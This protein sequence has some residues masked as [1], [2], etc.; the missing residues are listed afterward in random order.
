MNVGPLS[1]DAN[2]LVAFA[3]GHLT[4]TQ[5]RL[6]GNKSLRSEAVVHVPPPFIR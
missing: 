6:S 3:P 4:G 1:V 5:S 2:L